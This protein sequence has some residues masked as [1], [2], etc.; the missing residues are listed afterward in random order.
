MVDPE[1]WR[2]SQVPMINPDVPVE[3]PHSDVIEI[4]VYETAR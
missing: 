1:I 3:E 2:G 4:M